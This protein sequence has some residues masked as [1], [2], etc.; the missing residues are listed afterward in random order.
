LGAGSVPL[1]DFEYQA[2]TCSLPGHAWG[3]RQL[4]G[5][6]GPARCT[7]GLARPLAPR[8]RATRF[9]WPQ[10]LGLRDLSSTTSAE[11][12]RRGQAQENPASTKVGIAPGAPRRGQADDYASCDPVSPGRKSEP[13]CDPVLIGEGYSAGRCA[14]FRPEEP[15]SARR[16]PGSLR[17]LLVRPLPPR[18]LSRLAEH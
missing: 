3:V 12:S 4:P 18:S 16:H 13:P 17:L 2:P 7:D 8:V 14:R 9:L 15:A 1:D 10:P 5:P 6:W 11:Q